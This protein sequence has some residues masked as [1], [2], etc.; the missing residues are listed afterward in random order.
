MKP[1]STPQEIIALI[2]D[3]EEER[4]KKNEEAKALEIAKADEVRK[5]REAETSLLLDKVGYLIPD[6]IFPYLMFDKR[7]GHEPNWWERSL[8]FQIPGLAPIAMV[9]TGV[10]RGDEEPKL[11]HWSVAGVVDLD[12][13][14]D[15]DICKSAGFSFRGNV[16]S[17]AK[18]DSTNIRQVLW[19]AKKVFE[20]K[21]DRQIQLDQ[22]IA[23][24]HKRKQEQAEEA[25]RQASE[26][27]ALFD[28]IKN[29]PI[30]VHM[31]KAFVLLRDERSAFEQC[32]EEMGD[33]MYGMEDRWSRK[34]S[35]LR[36]QAEDAQR[37]A[38]DDRRRLESDLDD[39]EAKLKK[40]QQ[41]W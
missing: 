24:C 2:E 28:A 34:A 35:D 12:W 17:T 31:L 15:T 40:A 33:E 37:R 1:I 14:E 16:S 13:D 22:S 11:S 8:E 7:T 19:A 3:A 29:D 4:A 38:D 26:E 20:E 18:A 30:A 10:I 36:R 5:E 23:R 25:L 41:G 6:V 21:E 9:F 39:A 27:K 32:I